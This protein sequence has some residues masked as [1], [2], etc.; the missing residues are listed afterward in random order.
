MNGTWPRMPRSR[1]DRGAA[2]WRAVAGTVTALAAMAALTV[3]MLPVRAHL[4]IATAALVLVVPVV[5]GVVTG[6]FVAGV[7]SVAAGF[8]VYDF[9]FIPPY[10]TLVVGAPQNW[11]ALGVYVVVMLPVARVV[12]GLNVARARE[13][14]LSRELRRLFEIS[15][16]LVADRPLDDLLHLVVAELTEV[17]GARQAV[18]C[19]LSADRLEVAASAGEPLTA[20]QVDRLLAG[21]AGAA[22]ASGTAGAAIDAGSG[23]GRGTR[24]P[25]VR[26]DLLVLA[27]TAAGRP[28]GLLALSADAAVAHE[29]EPLL[30]FGNQIA[31][32]VERAQLRE[33][34]LETRLTQEV[35]RLA[36]I[37]V[38]AV[39]HDV[40][41][42]LATI[43]ASS[44]T[45][46]DPD[47]PLGPDASR[48]L[49]VLI[50]GQ[51]DRLSDLVRNLL[52]MSRIQAGVLRPRSGVTSVTALVSGVLDG[53]GP[54][55]GGHRVRLDLPRDL[56]PVDVD[57]LLIS[58][59]L[60]NLLE[61]AVR[62]SPPGAEIEIG[63]RTLPA[64]R[65]ELAVADSGPGVP[66]GQRD[67]IFGLFAR[68]AGDAGAGLGLAIA[69]TFVEAHGERI[70]VEAGP[71]G[72]ARFCCTLPV[73]AALSGDSRAMGEEA[74]DAAGADH[75]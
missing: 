59:V 7:V 43:K 57:E 49:A 71:G 8:L 69:K 15:D 55:L 12:S 25:E 42:P 58:R 5:I 74:R 18:I 41:S 16:L 19:L 1:S 70:W 29:R 30:L 48:N 56:P 73:A 6:G 31:L 9:F 38:A 32:A 24:T 37:L 45:L 35:A 39:A 11:A 66:P 34:A 75:R 4:S 36:R 63:A 46:A 64:G 60:A 27:L 22:G 65:V 14:R 13:R 67:E 47:I 26:G 54:T 10:Q 40:R 68:R 3:A 21:P 53:L 62:H 50:D 52:D 51:V 61:N 20:G 33:Q 2:S 44:S 72:G 23:V 17:V 28:V